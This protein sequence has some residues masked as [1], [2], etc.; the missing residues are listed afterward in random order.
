MGKLSSIFVFMLMINIVGYIMLSGMVEEG[1]ASG[2]SYLTE[3]TL[4]VKFYTPVLD[5][6]GQTVYMLSNQSALYTNV[7]Q[8]TP[9]SLI[10]EGI[11]FVDRIFVLFGFIQA[12]LGT[13]LFP[14]ALISFMGL[15]WQMSMLFFL[16]LMS[17]YI[18]GIID[19]LSGGNS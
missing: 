12:I 10:E 1:V 11:T 2:N 9:S 7:P 18:L 17:L 15:P 16:P 3:N 13:I 5:G 6:D 8:N 19:L 14:I 4:L